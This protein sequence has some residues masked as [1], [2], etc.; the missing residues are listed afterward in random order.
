MAVTPHYLPANI[1]RILRRRTLAVWH[2]TC[3]SPYLQW[4]PE[5]VFLQV[6]TLWHPANCD[7]YTHI[8][9]IISAFLTHS[10][11]L[12]AVKGINERKLRVD[13]INRAA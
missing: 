9:H 4:L 12:E 10:A 3:L 6:L 1:Y 5:D 11:A 2:C 13:K 7:R 8:I